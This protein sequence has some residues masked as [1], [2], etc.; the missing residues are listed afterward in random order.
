MRI[1]IISDVHGNYLALASVVEDA[2]SHN[3]DKFVFVGD[4]IFD[5]PFSDEVVRLL[6][7]LENAYIVKGN[8][9]G[10]LNNLA[11]DNQDNWTLQQFEVIYQIFRELSPDAYD[12]LTGLDEESYITVSPTISIYAVH[13]P[14]N[15]TLPHETNCHALNFRKKMLDEPF[16]HEEFLSEFSDLVNSD[17]NKAQIDQIDAN[18]IVFGHNH[19]QSYCYCGDKLIINPG[20]CGL[21]L[22]FNTAAPYSIL[23]E[24]DNGL[25][26]TERRVTYDIQ[27][28]ISEAKKSLAYEKGRI[29]SDIIFLQLETGRDYIGMFFEIAKGIAAS[30]NEQQSHFSNS[31]WEEAYEVFMK[32]V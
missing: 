5:L 12:F 1:A 22:D 17:E 28:V 8:K 7:N 31:T 4:Y 25:T 6:M 27:S 24:T 16:S 14:K 10:Y 18:V 11:N 32:K 29:W 23:E 30:K 9:E 15:F 3:V 13:F 20:S 26:V 19:L 21:P 2:I